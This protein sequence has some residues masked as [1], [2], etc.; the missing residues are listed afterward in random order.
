MG[1]DNRR[2]SHHPKGINIVNP[3]RLLVGHE[4]P[5]TGIQRLNAGDFMRQEMNGQAGNKKTSCVR[6]ERERKA[7]HP[8]EV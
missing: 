8:Q 7:R 5:F 1:Q 6:R 2:D 4:N 3:D